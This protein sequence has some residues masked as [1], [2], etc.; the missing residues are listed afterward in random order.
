MNAQKA[1]SRSECLDAAKGICI[2]LVVMF[3]TF[4]FFISKNPQFLEA[5]S[6]KDVQL[7][8][9]G[10]G[11]MRM[12]LFFLISGYLAHTAVFN[13][14]W[15]EIFE[16]RVAMLL[17]LYILWVWLDWLFRDMLITHFNPVFVLG[18]EDVP[19]TIDEF[20]HDVI[21]GNT[22]IWYLYALVL[23]F[24][25]CKI[26]SQHKWL[27][28]SV[29]LLISV[30]CRQIFSADQWSMRIICGNVVFF[31][32][33]CFGKHYVEHITTHFS[34]RNFILAFSAFL[35]FGKITLHYDAFDLPGVR[36]LICTCLVIA[37]LYAISLAT[38]HLKL[39]LLQNLG[40][41]TLPIYVMHQFIIN[42]AAQLIFPI[43]VPTN[44]LDLGLFALAG[45]IAINI[46]VCLFLYWIL[47][48]QY[49]RILF[50]LPK[51]ELFKVKAAQ[52]ELG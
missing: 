23:F 34:L 31:C 11:T 1:S 38:R 35:L 13:R 46:S 29:L 41:K 40:R 50:S 43:D 20:L 52:R 25:A 44:H 45:F 39:E 33:G 42:I 26:G 14:S 36:I 5:E 2:I 37:S 6:F 47:N 3:H 12:P 27:T 28:F 48:R 32:A 24:S 10:L 15:R 9:A 7:I 17:W 30:V 49:G 22:P 19:Q 8:I 21:T 16:P 51:R 18:G 4:N